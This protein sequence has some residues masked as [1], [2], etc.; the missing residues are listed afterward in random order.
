MKPETFKFVVEQLENN[1][2]KLIAS[3]TVMADGSNVRSKMMNQAFKQIAGEEDKTMMDAG[4]KIMLS[5]RPGQLP[6]MQEI[7]NSVQATGKAA[8]IASGDDLER[9][10]DQYRREAMKH[11]NILTSPPLG[12]MGKAGIRLLHLWQSGTLTLAG[13]GVECDKLDK[14]F[15]GVGWAAAGKE[16]IAKIGKPPEYCCPVYGYIE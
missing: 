12:D 3:K 6:S 15:P 7:I 16:F 14:K 11:E 5:M 4:D 9:A 8:R 1:A 2:G 10:A 13:Y